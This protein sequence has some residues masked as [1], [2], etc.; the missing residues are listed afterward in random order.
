MNE[1]RVCLISHEDQ[2]PLR[3]SVLGQGLPPDVP[4][5]PGDDHPDTC[6]VG[7]YAGGI[8]VS[9]A[10]LYH[11]PQP[12]HDSATHWRL[13]GMA[14]LPDHAGQGYGTLALNHCIEHARRHGGTRIWCNARDDARGFYARMMFR[15]V[16]EPYII[17]GHHRGWLMV[18]EL[19]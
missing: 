14:T 1:A 7:V 17:G 10:S 12:E 5:K 13:R 15:T 3:R 18:R 4:V 11:E 9:I 2:Y 19:A 8:L 16:G 6:H